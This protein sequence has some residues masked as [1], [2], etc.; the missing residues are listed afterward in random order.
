ME[1]KDWRN[2]AAD[3]LTFSRKE[4]WAVMALA[5]V[6]VVLLILPRFIPETASRVVEEDSLA[7]AVIK[8]WQR[9]S[10]AYRRQY[11][12]D[13]G[14]WTRN[15]PATFTASQKLFYFDPNTAS[16]GEWMQLG[17]RE[18]TALTISRFLEKGGRFR[19]ADDLNNIYGLP[20]ALADKLKPYVRIR[21]LTDHNP[22]GNKKS[23][24]DKPRVIAKVNINT[25]DSAVL[26]ALPGIG[27]KLASRIVAYRNKLGGFYRVGQLLEVYGIR[28]TLLNTLVP[29]L[30]MDPGMPLQVDINTVDREELS[31]H[32]YFR[33]P[34]ANAVISYRDAHG[35]YQSIGDLMKIHLAD[36]AW[37]R[38]VEPYCKFR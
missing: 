16:P 12:N 17:V 26:V 9:D 30:E 24:P 15:R 10:P 20:A 19:K 32:P 2:W 35:A 31:K 14:K 1:K 34:M 4:R 28:D 36:T 18:K 5:L 8:L 11:N 27:P 6:L 3:Y 29:Y 38:K 37:L 22:P 13:T 23:W 7:M 25:A 33:G 21:E